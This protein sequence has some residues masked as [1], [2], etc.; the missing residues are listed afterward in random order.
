MDEQAFDRMVAEI[1][2]AVMAPSGFQH[3]IEQLVVAFGLKA[4]MLYRH[5]VVD[6][7]STGVWFSGLEPRWLES[8]AV[9]YGRQD[10]LAHY[11]ATAPVASFYATNLHL[12][13]TDYADSAFYREWVIP[14][15]VACAAAAIVLQEGAWRSQMV[16]QRSRFQPPFSHAEL[17]QLDRLLAHLQHAL[18]MRERFID[19]QAGHHLLTAGL[20]VLAIPAL[21]FDESGRVAYQNRAAAAVLDKRGWLRVDGRH[22]CANDPALT[23]HI[24][25]KV[26]AALDA[27]RRDTPA[28]SGVVLVPRSGK[29]PLT[30]MIAPVRPAGA[31]IRG[32][33]VL[34]LYDAAQSSGANAQLVGAI[35]ALTRAEAELVVALCAGHTLEQA[36]ALRNT[37]PHT[38]RSQL[39]SIFNKTGTHRQADLLA[40]VLS[41]PACFVAL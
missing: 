19:L 21:M 36:A 6:G 7:E 34:F 12:A 2:A 26:M 16:L 15:G 23:L 41:S 33:A 31:A 10:M 32:A 29:P 8:Y 17:R 1:Y 18:R 20:D 25:L 11:L 30:L 40:L 39:K 4:A 27:S 37:S 14:Q 24:N 35:F 5:N 9:E 28:A 38:A 13:T 3:F 22:L